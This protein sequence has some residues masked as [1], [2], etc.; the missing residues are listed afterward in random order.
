MRHKNFL[1]QLQLQKQIEKEAEIQAEDD[2]ENAVV[3]FKE[4]AKKQ[5]ERIMNL[6]QV[7][8]PNEDDIEASIA[9]IAERHAAQQSTE[10]KPEPRV[11]HK[12]D[13]L[14]KENLSKHES[15]SQVASSQKQK[16]KAKGEKP[17]WAVTEKM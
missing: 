12:P 8:Q 11:E 5:R 17:A 14:T 9:K 15:I 3:K 6:K 13:P 4:Q 2:K 16:K 10:V 7:E 1:K